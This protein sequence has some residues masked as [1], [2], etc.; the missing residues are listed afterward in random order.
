MPVVFRRNVDS[1]LER[2][3][4]LSLRHVGSGNSPTVHTR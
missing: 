4:T 3:S 2:T 1:G